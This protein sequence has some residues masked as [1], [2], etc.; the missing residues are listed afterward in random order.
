MPSLH[1]F[2]SL[3]IRT[4][5]TIAS[6]Q[7]LSAAI[8]LAGTTMLGLLM[9]ASWTTANL[10][11][12]ASADGV[13]FADVYTEAGSEKTLTAAA[14]R[15]ILLEPADFTGVRFLKL[16]SGTS[17]AAVNQGA[18]RSITLLSRAL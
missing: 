11:L 8:D 2:Q 9:P 1:H 16:R 6:G 18:D 12:Q 3:L 14:S 15:F 17:A 5:V 13:T 7:S 4:P 10:T